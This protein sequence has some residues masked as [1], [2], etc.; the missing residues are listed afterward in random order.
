MSHA[1]Q[2]SLQQQQRLHLRS[3]QSKGILFTQLPGEAIVPFHRDG[4]KVSKKEGV[5]QAVRGKS[6]IFCIKL[7]RSLDAEGYDLCL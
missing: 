1:R 6:S 2:T 7:M 4:E 5:V 3:L